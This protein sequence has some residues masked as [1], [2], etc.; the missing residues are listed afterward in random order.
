MNRTTNNNAF[1]VYVFLWVV[2]MANSVLYAANISGYST[3]FKDGDSVKIALWK[4]GYHLGPENARVMYASIKNQCFNIEIE[5]DSG[6]VFHMNISLPVGAR[7]IKMFR[8]QLLESGDNILI[9]EINHQWVL[10]GKGSKKF[11]VL[12]KLDDIKKAIS[13]MS[14]MQNADS[15]IRS[16]RR[17]DEVFLAQFDY[18][19]SK[20]ANL[21]SSIYLLISAEI[22]SDNINTKVTWARSLSNS[23]A[24]YIRQILVRYKSPVNVANLADKDIFDALKYSISYPSAVLNELWLNEFIANKRSES[25]VGRCRQF[26]NSHFRGQLRERLITELFLTKRKDTRGINELL[27]Q[28]LITF[29]NNEFKEMLLRL[30]MRRLKGA[31]AF[32]FALPDTNNAIVTLNDISGKVVVIDFWYTGCL[33]CIELVPYLNEVEESFS[34]SPVTFISV[35]ADKHPDTWRQSIRS[36]KYTTERGI[37]LLA[38]KNHPLLEH[39]QINAFPTLVLIDKNGY[40]MDTPIDP[41]ADGGNSL[42]SLIK[43]ALERY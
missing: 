19:K 35:S 20:E 30:K 26:I 8:N 39:Y 25:D 9:R 38:G 4:Y 2:C 13:I 42:H 21:D 41:R 5:L 37:N 27:D 3:N 24:D 10:Q 12:N 40:I 36:S 11:C 23:N 6:A 15:L 14:P 17:K 32:E 18:L 1:I 28:E 16:F 22:I 7:E 29:T 33:N 34:G 31:K 43:E